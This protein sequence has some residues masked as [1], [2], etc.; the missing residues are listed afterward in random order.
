ME[1]ARS[2]YVS[3]EVNTDEV[4][5]GWVTCCSLQV[6]GRTEQSLEVNDGAR[7]EVTQ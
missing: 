6:K 7:V 3:G 5:R 4:R 2:G 1:V